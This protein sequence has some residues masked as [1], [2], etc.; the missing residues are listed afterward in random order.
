MCT[1]PTAFLPILYG[2]KTIIAII[3]KTDVVIVVLCLNN[4]SLFISV[5]GNWTVQDKSDGKW[6]KEEKWRYLLSITWFEYL[7]V[8]R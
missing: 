8:G 6:G 1:S 3:K 4:I 2:K 5:D 7:G